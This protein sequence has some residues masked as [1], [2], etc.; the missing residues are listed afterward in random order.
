MRLLQG[1]QT[2]FSWYACAA[3]GFMGYQGAVIDKC[4]PPETCCLVIIIQ[5]IF[6]Y[7]VL[8]LQ[9]Y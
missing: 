8:S 6:S 4:K 9:G 1:L 7:S 3:L 2:W 5:V